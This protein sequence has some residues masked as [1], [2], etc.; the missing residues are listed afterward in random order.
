MQ[1]DSW[2]DADIEAFV[3]TVSRPRFLRYLASSADDIRLAFTLYRWNSEISQ[4]FYLPL[5]IWEI[6]LRNRLNNFLSDRFG[7][8]WAI[9]DDRAW[10][11]LKAN[12]RRR[13]AGALDKQR[14]QRQQP[15]TNNSV[16]ADLSAGFWVGLLGRGYEVPFAWRSNLQRVFPGGQGLPREAIW[17]ICDD[18]L[19][20]RNRIAHHEPIFH[21][22]L[23]KQHRDLES[24]LEALCPY[25]H[26]YAFDGSRL[27]QLWARRPAL[28]E[29]R[30]GP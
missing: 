29:R 26:R 17:A 30:S 23:A 19:K 20:L 2:S 18:L 24:L 15:P 10:R 28:P 16:V 7:P 22:D 13:V 4:Y 12:E 14:R 25:A 8:D 21:L 5:Q 3:Q 6:A 9:H 1:D 27:D 11:A